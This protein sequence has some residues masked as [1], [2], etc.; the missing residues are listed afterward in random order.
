MKIQYEDEIVW[1]ASTIE[2]KISWKWILYGQGKNG[3][4][5]KICRNVASLVSPLVLSS[6]HTAPLPN[7]LLLHTLNIQL[8]ECLS[9]EQL[10]I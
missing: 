4:E 7:A 2:K 6:Q 10:E 5:I 8:I 3:T 9:H 1:I